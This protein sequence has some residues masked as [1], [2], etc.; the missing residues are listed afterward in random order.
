MLIRLLPLAWAVVSL[1]AAQPNFI[2]IVGEDLGPELGCYGDAYAR[3][4]NLDKLAAEGARFTRAFTHAPVCAPSRSGLITGQYPIKIGSHH[5]RSKLLEPPPAF[6]THLRR[7]G[8]F[9]AWPGKTDFNFNIPDDYF[10]STNNWRR[11][12]PRRPFFAYI[13]MGE[14]H[15]SKIRQ[16]QDAFDKVTAVLKPEQRHNPALAPVP[17]YHSDTPIVRRDLAKYYDL[18]SVVDNRVGEIL[19]QLEE[20]GLLENTVIFFFGDHGRG[21]PRS[22]R[23]VYDSGIRVPLIIKWPGQ[24]KAGTVR[25]ELVSFVDFGSTVLSVAEVAIPKEVDG[26]PFLGPNATPRKYIYAHRDRM[27]ETPDRIRAVRDERFKYIRNFETNLPYA[28]RI[29]YMEEMP[30]M[31]EWRRLNAEGK[32]I[33]AQKLFFSPTKPKEELYDTET[34]PHEIYNLAA[35]PQHAAKLKELRG[36]LEDW[37]RKTGD[38]GQIPERELIKRG[39]VADSLS[40]Y[41]ERKAPG[42]RS[43]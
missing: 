32:L 16:P 36:A 28:Q 38:L 26:Q 14:S 4:P 9:V 1:A 24:I 22:K 37:I 25:E 23:W 15:E 21:L 13:N 8:Y 33:V 17:P 27:D 19:R 10:D 34:D 20:N 30:T 31:R 41:E 42:Y 12:P 3:T 35:L 39:L 6:T 43:K 18:V 40:Q 11:N 7:A 29:V 2:W 5:M